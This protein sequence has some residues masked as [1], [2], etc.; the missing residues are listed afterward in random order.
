[1]EPLRKRPRLGSKMESSHVLVKRMVEETVV[2]R[3]GS[4]LDLQHEQHLPGDPS[5]SKGGFHIRH[6]R[7]HRRDTNSDRQHV[8]S[9]HKEPDS[10]HRKAESDHQGEKSANKHEH[11]DVEHEVP[12]REHEKP[13]KE[14]K[15]SDK[16]HQESDEDH[17]E[18]AKQHGD[19]GEQHTDRDHYPPGS[20]H[21]VVVV[22][23][24]VEVVPVVQAAAAPGSSPVL[25]GPDG[26]V[27]VPSLPAPSTQPRSSPILQSSVPAASVAPAI[28]QTDLPSSILTSNA[29]QS[30]APPV[31]ASAQQAAN[32]PSNSAPV[33]IPNAV[34]Q[35]ASLPAGPP[36]NP[37]PQPPAPLAPQFA[38]QSPAAAAAAAMPTAVGSVPIVT[39]LPPPNLQ[40]SGSA[41]SNIAPA[42]ALPVPAIPA[43]ALPAA[44]QSQAE[45]AIAQFTAA[46]PSA[47]ADGATSLATTFIAV[48]PQPSGAILSASFR[49][50]LAAVS[51]GPQ[52][53][54]GV[55][56]VSVSFT[57]QFSAG[58]PDSADG[59]QLSIGAATVLAVPGPTGAPSNP[60]VPSD[61]SGAAPSGNTG[62]A[63][64]Q[65][66]P[67]ASA[68]G[69]Q[70]TAAADLLT[71]SASPQPSTTANLAAGQSIPS[72]PA[73]AS[74][75]SS[76]TTGSSPTTT[77]SDQTSASSTSSNFSNFVTSGQSDTTLTTSSSP[78]I[79]VPFQSIATLSDGS[80]TTITSNVASSI[81]SDG[82]IPTG[83]GRPGSGTGSGSGAAP[84]NSPTNG[85]GAGSSQG[86][87]SPSVPVPTVVGG[88]V[89]GIAGIAIF[90]ILLL[91]L[92][93]W[94]RKRQACKRL[95]AAGAGTGT[96]AT[97]ASSRGIGP[98]MQSSTGLSAPFIAAAALARRWRPKSGT[99][100]LAAGPSTERSFV[101]VAGRKLPRG[102]DGYGGG[103]DD[104]SA[105]AA[106]SF[107][108]PDSDVLPQGI[109]PALAA[110]PSVR[111]VP[112]GSASSSAA[113]A[114]I[115][116]Q[117]P[118]PF[119]TGPAFP[120][121][122]DSLDM[123][124][125][126]T[127]GPSGSPQ[128]AGLAGGEGV[129]M[130]PGPGR[131]FETSTVPIMFPTPP[132][133]PPRFGSAGQSRPWINRQDTGS[134]ASRFSENVD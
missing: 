58:L 97:M 85:I 106:S 15:E 99:A 8:D 19:S 95:E 93:R 26:Q 55:A 63:S 22:S 25:Q 30:S 43:A 18:S 24:V 83:A 88:V 103:Y 67:E 45:S 42:A 13:D 5:R 80:L 132:R 1:M 125:A 66:F 64:A 101:R 21:P 73:A 128:E 50:D 120:E 75:R 81:E 127:P 91:V 56:G 31:P 84:S 131:V 116:Y 122:R 129:W 90:F 112:P 29:I 10:D 35:P 111:Q 105:Y 78:T 121:V 133:T 134:R 74:L 44:A 62:K 110:G 7:L 36:Q 14:H 89:A 17:G 79:P 113:A 40:P 38:P 107:L 33:L 49:A 108:R 72:T 126:Q 70:A 92:M 61:V 87:A 124:Q 69:S 68:L 96:G 118:R 32:P 6:E 71:A 115:P 59:S 60:S 86:Q 109:N 104:A 46:L 65:A 47:I 94:Y 76:G 23:A 98:E 39:G 119:A 12:D 102:G 34:G 82:S 20:S 57:A 100:E 37:Q 51:A 2:R 9:D 54:S 48:L 16:K 77:S 130:R 52:L 28:T 53:A 11:P 27:S 41:I 123:F 4:G 114:T 117:H 3:L